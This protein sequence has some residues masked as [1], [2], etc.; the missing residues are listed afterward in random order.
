M[1]RSPSRPFRTY[2]DGTEGEAYAAQ[3]GLPYPFDGGH[4]D[5]PTGAG[6]TV[7]VSDAVC[8]GTLVV[9]GEILSPVVGCRRFSAVL[10]TD[11]DARVTSLLWWEADGTLAQVSQD[12]P[13]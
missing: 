1:T 2:V 4:L 12:Y 10:A 11:A 13:G 9:P 7:D 5:V 8:T 3:H 6:R